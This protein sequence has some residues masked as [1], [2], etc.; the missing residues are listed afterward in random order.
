[1]LK[2][3][4]FDLDDTLY[5]FWDSEKKAIEA[6][7]HALDVH[8]KI[9]Y[10]IFSQMYFSVG[11]KVA[12]QLKGTAAAHERILTFQHIVE[13]VTGK[14]NV[15]LV[16]ALNNAYWETFFASMNIGEGVKETLQEIRNRK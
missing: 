9:S 10:E 3:I 8:H 7:Y 12:D 5:S 13:K 1:M 11:K 14:G 4:L 6:T 2:G 16:L 15:T